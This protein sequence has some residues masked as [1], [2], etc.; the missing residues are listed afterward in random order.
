MARR[1]RVACLFGG[2]PAR[3]GNRPA[4]PGINLPGAWR[5]RVHARGSFNPVGALRMLPTILR[6]FLLLTLYWASLT[7]WLRLQSGLYH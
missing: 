1:R 2:G 7:S 5:M 4:L 6:L 3:L